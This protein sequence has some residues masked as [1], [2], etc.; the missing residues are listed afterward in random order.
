[1]LSDDKNDPRNLTFSQSQDYEPLPSLLALEELSDDARREIWDL[2]YDSIK[3][4]A[5]IIEWGVSPP[6]QRLGSLDGG[7]Y[8]IALELHREIDK[9]PKR[10]FDPDASRFLYKYEAAILDGEQPFNKVFD[11]LQII[12]RNPG[13]PVGFNEAVQDIF[14]KRRLAYY[15]DTNGP[16]TIFPMATQQ[17]GAAIRDAMDTL[18]GAGLA[19]AAEHLRKSQERINEVDWSGSIRESIHAVESVARY[20]DPKSSKILGPALKSLEANRQL[21]PSLKL[22]FEKLYGYTSDEEGIRHPLMNC[23][24]SSSGRDEALFLLS[25]CAAFASYLWRVKKDTDE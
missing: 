15:V 10:D 8:K 2:L 18:Q 14:E 1:M 9:K 22:A 16:A 6:H 25:T 19:G 12:M 21:H 13:R 7:W 20:L 3:S 24:E 4:N 23:T 11:I 5:A 17:E